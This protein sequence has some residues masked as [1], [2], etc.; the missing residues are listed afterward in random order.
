MPVSKG[1]GRHGT[2]ETVPNDV[3]WNLPSAQERTLFV[4][5]CTSDSASVIFDSA[6]QS[7][8]QT[9]RGVRWA[10]S[11]FAFD[12]WAWQAQLSDI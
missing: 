4:S 5:L 12:F 6:Q 3:E 11:R 1:T 7:E 8:R 10:D 2:Q 9:D